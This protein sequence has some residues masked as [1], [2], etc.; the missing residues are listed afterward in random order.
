[1]S[2]ITVGQLT[3]FPDG[4]GVGVVIAG[5]RLA[6][7]RLGER[8]F[9]IDDA[10]PHR[11]FPLNDG[12]VNGL[13]LRCRTHGSCFDLETGAVVRGPAAIGVRTYRVR[14]DGDSV[15]VEGDF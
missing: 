1:M 15:V 9:A 11:G 10:C 8:L 3:N 7:F 12:V 6:I 13:M 5:R 2:P 4:Q 14:I